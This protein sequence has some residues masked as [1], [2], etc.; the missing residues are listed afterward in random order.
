MFCLSGWWLRVF[1]LEFAK[2]YIS[3]WSIPQYV[4]VQMFKSVKQKLSKL[5]QTKEVT[6]NSRGKRSCEKKEN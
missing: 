4:R 1:A 6:V 2:L 3:V 5:K